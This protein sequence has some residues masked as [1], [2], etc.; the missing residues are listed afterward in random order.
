MCK[1]TKSWLC[2][3][4]IFYHCL[5]SVWTVHNLVFAK[6]TCSTTNHSPRTQIPNCNQ[7]KTRNL[8]WTRWDLH[9]CYKNSHQHILQPRYYPK[10]RIYANTKTTS[11]LHQ[12]IT[13][14][15]QDSTLPKTRPHMH[16][17]KTRERPKTTI[18]QT[19]Y[20]PPPRTWQTPLPPNSPPSHWH[21]PSPPEHPWPRPTRLHNWWLHKTMPRTTNGNHQAFQ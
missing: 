6:N 2:Y 16:A 9:R 15:W 1:S 17:P 20:Y 10:W 21:P 12:R 5:K 18:K 19:A 8:P 4:T 3:K 14:T 13:P 7:N 11:R